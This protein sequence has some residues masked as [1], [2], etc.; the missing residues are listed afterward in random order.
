MIYVRMLNLRL[1]GLAARINFAAIVYGQSSISK[2][3]KR[4]FVRFVGR[5]CRRLDWTKKEELR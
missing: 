1:H 3:R 4:L 5:K 2:I